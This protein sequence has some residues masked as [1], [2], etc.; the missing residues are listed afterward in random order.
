M[1]QCMITRLRRPLPDEALMH[2]SLDVTKVPKIP[3]A[4][5]WENAQL[6]CE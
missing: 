1:R 3:L 6:N 5:N 2:R 4:K